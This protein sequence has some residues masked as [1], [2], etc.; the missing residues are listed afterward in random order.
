[1][2]KQILPGILLLVWVGGWTSCGEPIVYR[3]PVQLSQLAREQI[4]NGNYVAALD[5]LSRIVKESPDTDHALKASL[6]R[7]ALLGGLAR[8]YQRLGQIYLEGYDNAMSVDYRSELQRTAKD[9]FGQAQT[10]VLELVE[11]LD[12]LLPTV[13]GKTLVIDVPLLTVPA[14]EN[15]AVVR[16]RAG[17]RLLD[18]E[19][20][21]IEPEEI[22]RG[23]VEMMAALVGAAEDPARARSL[24]AQGNTPLEPGTFFLAVGKELVELSGIFDRRALNNPNFHRLLHERAVV[25]ADKVL[26]AVK[27]P[28]SPLVR[29]AQ[30]LQQQCRRVLQKS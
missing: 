5:T 14:E 12:A 13:E 10:R 15:A 1:M 19:R 7:V 22:R 28:D 26:L 11:T 16:L 23:L 3:G 20:A 6:L 30:K 17:R 27:K 24:Y 25:A 4:V 18:A 9:Y 2:K 21:Q 8:G 29:E